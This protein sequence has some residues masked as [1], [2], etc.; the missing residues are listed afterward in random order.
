MIREVKSSIPGHIRIRRKLIGDPRHRYSRASHCLQHLLGIDYPNNSH[1]PGHGA[2]NHRSNQRQRHLKPDTRRD[3][4]A[5]RVHPDNMS[6]KISTADVA[7]NNTE[8]AA[9][10]IVSLQRSPT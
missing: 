1:T 10:V 3:S 5:D 6:K 7:K 4:P 2:R 8:Q 9:W